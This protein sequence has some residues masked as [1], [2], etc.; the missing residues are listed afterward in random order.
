MPDRE[1]RRQFLAPVL[2]ELVDQ[3]VVERAGTLRELRQELKPPASVGEQAIGA[4]EQF[5]QRVG[6]VVR[7]VRPYRPVR[8]GAASPTRSSSSMPTAGEGSRAGPRTAGCRACLRAPLFHLVP[9]AVVERAQRAR[10]VAGDDAEGR[11]MVP[12]KT[13]QASKAPARKP[14][15]GIRLGDPVGHQHHVPRCLA[16]SN[17]RPPVT[18]RSK[19]SASSG[20][21][22]PRAAA[23]Q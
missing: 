3:H 17:G 21:T 9:P 6:L 23:A 5:R 12:R 13:V 20:P 18:A 7:P 2:G 8:P 14:A 11:E 15:I 4:S 19:P 22:A 10:L 16:A 1:A